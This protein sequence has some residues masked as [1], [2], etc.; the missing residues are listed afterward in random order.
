MIPVRSSPHGDFH[1]F[2][3]SSGGSRIITR[4]ANRIYIIMQDGRRDSLR[5][6]ERGGK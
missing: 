1:Y 3:V 4:V 6:C 5:V 2:N